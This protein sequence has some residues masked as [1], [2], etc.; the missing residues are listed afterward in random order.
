MPP[1][2]FHFFL[3]FRLPVH[4]AKNKFSVEFEIDPNIHPYILCL[5]LDNNVDILQ[6]YKSNEILASNIPYHPSITE[7][8]VRTSL[9]VQF[10]HSWT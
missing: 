10:L 7:N 9:H 3:S 5:R 4:P 6:Y 2:Y 1:V 8:T